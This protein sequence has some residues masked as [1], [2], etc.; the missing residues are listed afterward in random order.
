[1]TIL[2]V[3]NI[4]VLF[5]NG[6]TSLLDA[7]GYV[8][9]TA[10][11]TT[12]QA[13]LNFGLS[14]LFVMVFEWG[15]AGVAA[16]TLV[17]RLLTSNAV[18]PVYICRKIGTSLWRFLYE[19]IGRGMLCGGIFASTCLL[20]QQLIIG[21]SWIQFWVQVCLS[22]VCYVPI[23]IVILIPAHD[24]RRIFAKLRPNHHGAG[25]IAKD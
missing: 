16:G 23:A 6:A 22:L 9:F 2:S 18:L 4:L 5:R 25:V 15:L 3:S 21:E 17:A 20:V 12:V 14:L 7:M 10:S 11:L 19:T 8:R 24:R 1:M 13:G